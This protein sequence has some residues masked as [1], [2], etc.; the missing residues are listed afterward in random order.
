MSR[1][2]RTYTHFISKSDVDWY[3]IAEK[4]P[5][6]HIE[7]VAKAHLSSSSD[8]PV[9]QANCFY[10]SKNKSWHIVDDIY[11]G[12]NGSLT[13]KCTNSDS[14]CYAN[15]FKQL[16]KKNYLRRRRERKLQSSLEASRE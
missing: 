10:D 14:W 15:E 11:K 5:A 16:V 2:N 9:L 6:E 3:L 8:S 13:I 12:S 7:V 1:P 4:K